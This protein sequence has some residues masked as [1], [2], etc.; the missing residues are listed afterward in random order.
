VASVSIKTLAIQ[1]RNYGVVRRR[2]VEGAAGLG[3]AV[4]R[5]SAFGLASCAAAVVVA[6]AV[7]D[8]LSRHSPADS[9][10]AEQEEH[11]VAAE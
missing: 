9:G 6:V 3:F 1:I 11:A 2:A 4:P 7:L 10:D 5:L 8:S